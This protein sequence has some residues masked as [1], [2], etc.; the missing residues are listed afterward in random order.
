LGGTIAGLAG[1]VGQRQQIRLRQALSPSVHR[2]TIPSVR[3]GLATGFG[4][5]IIAGTLQAAIDV[6]NMYVE[7]ERERELEAQQ[8]PQTADT[9]TSED[10]ES[11]P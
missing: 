7:R 2:P 5:G 8:P 6:G 9:D 1:A 3:F 10:E 11:E 4:L